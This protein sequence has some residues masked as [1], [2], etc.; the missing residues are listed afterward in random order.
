MSNS[1]RVTV[2]NEYRHEP[3]DPRIAAVYPEGIHNA[4]AGGLKDYGFE[5]KTATMDQPEHGLSEA[6]LAK[7]DVLV[8]WSHIANHEVNDE[9]V[10]RVHKRVLNEGMGL[11]TLHSACMS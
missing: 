1:V 8:W 11:I 9:I 3:N 5:V 6:V 10:E 4:I 7:T 2:W